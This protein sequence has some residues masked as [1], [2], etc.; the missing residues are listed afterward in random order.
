VLLRDA[1]VSAE[2]VAGARGEGLPWEGPKACARSARVPR[3]AAELAVLGGRPAFAEPLHVGRP[4]LPD[5]DRLL[6]RL[7]GVLD[8]RWLTNDGP[9]VRELERRLAER[10]QVAHCVAVCNATIGLELAMHALGISGEVIVPAFTFVATAHSARWMRLQPVFADVDPATHNLD[11]ADVERRITNK[12]S[13]IVGVHV[14]GRACAPEA[15]EDI[16]RR[17]RLALL[18]DAAHAFDCTHAGRPIGGFGLAEVFSFHATKFFNSFE[19]GAVATNDDDLARRLRLMRNFGFT[20]YDRVDAIGTN[21]KMCEVAAAM[22]LASLE[23]LED[24][25]AVNRRNHAAYRERLERLPGL[26]V[27][28]YEGPDRVNHQYVVCEVDAEKAGLTRDELWRTL[29]ADNVIA[30]RY[31]HPGVHRMQ[32]YASEQ[33]PETRNLPQT[34]RLCGR[35]LCFP[36]GQTIDESTIDRVCGVVAAALSDPE[37]VRRAVAALP[38]L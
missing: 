12:T 10:L 11:P 37:P 24:V 34:E 2:S 17:R 35:V 29:F 18:F 14:W 31:F 19:G 8:S 15:L 26:C 32:P 9:Q 3:T 27:V 16:C 22:G 25:V 13:A 33:K 7:A 21:G 1:V 4:N 38:P 20:G 36:T 30:R 28:R 23:S 6:E 5:R